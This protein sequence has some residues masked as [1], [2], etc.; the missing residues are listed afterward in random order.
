VASIAGNRAASATLSGTTV[1]TVTLN[2]Y[3]YYK[4]V[5]HSVAATMWVTLGDGGLTPIDP[6]AAAADAFPVPPQAG[7]TMLIEN[8]NPAA[9]GKTVLKILG[10]ANVYTV[11]GVVHPFAVGAR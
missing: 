5:N 4:I 2:S 3:P 1:D 10:N 7:A 11:M 6:A 9:A 8:N